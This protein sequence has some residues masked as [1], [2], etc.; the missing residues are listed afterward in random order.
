LQR[1][2]ERRER[3][4]NNI[5]LIESVLNLIRGKALVFDVRLETEAEVGEE[6]KDLPD[7]WRRRAYSARKVC[8]FLNC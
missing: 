1:E 5:C 7:E 3:D 2:E 8:N 4:T 6:T